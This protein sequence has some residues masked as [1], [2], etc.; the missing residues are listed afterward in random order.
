MGRGAWQDTVH[1]VT[2]VGHDFATKPSP[3]RQVLELMPFGYQ[4]TTVTLMS[5]YTQRR[6]N[7]HPSSPSCS[8]VNCNS[9]YCMAAGQTFIYKFNSK[10]SLGIKAQTL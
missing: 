2:R 3:P 6:G 1:G 4:G 8:R 10:F 5:S 9:I 7:Q